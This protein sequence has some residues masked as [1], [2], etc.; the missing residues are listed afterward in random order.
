MT[1]TWGTYLSRISQGAPQV[2]IARAAGVDPATISRWKKGVGGQPS[3]TSVIQVCRQYG[4]SPV[5]G[6]I[7]A[8]HLAADDV[9]RVVELG[10][11][12]GAVGDRD[13]L[14]EIARRM[15]G[16]RDEDAGATKSS[17]T[18]GSSGSVRNSGRTPM[19]PA[20]IVGEM[21]RVVADRSITGPRQAIALEALGRQLSALPATPSAEGDGDAGARVG[22]GT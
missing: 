6:L 11:D 13:L 9:E 5:E 22:V 8:G 21:E 17:T 2:A 14:R 7:V 3:A 19:T 1:E 15:Q 12:L 18:S 16:V 4:R 20:E 10:T